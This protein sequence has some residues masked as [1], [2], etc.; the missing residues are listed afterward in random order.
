MCL[1]D[2]STRAHIHS[3]T[4]VHTNTHATNT[5]T[6]THTNTQSCTLTYKPQAH[7]HTHTQL[8][9]LTHK[10]QTRTH[11]HTHQIRSQGYSTPV[12]WLKELGRSSWLS[13][14]NIRG[15]VTWGFRSFPTPAAKLTRT[16]PRLSLTCTLL[17]GAFQWPHSQA[18]TNRE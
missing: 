14:L 2:V 16:R 18:S 17:S 6:H 7:T 5:L 4:I 10:P 8:C 1:G 13:S 11:T 15:H 12:A 9:A 3:H